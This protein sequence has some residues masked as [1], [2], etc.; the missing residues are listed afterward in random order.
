MDIGLLSLLILGSMLILLLTGLPVALILIVIA[1]V[2]VMVIKG[3]AALT[4][5]ASATFTSIT[6]DVF[7]ALP[8]FIFMAAVLE[9]SG[10]GSA[11]YDL[12]HKWMAGLRGGLAMGTIGIATAM[13]AMSGSAST[14][15]L[16]MGMLAYPEME[17]RGY[18][19]RMAIG[20][21]PAGGVLGPLIPPSVLMII[22]ASVSATSIGKLFMAG[23]IPGLLMSL[24]F[25]AYIGIRC[26][27]RPDMGPPLPVAERVGWSEKIKSVR[28]AFL[29]FLLILL[30]LG[31]IYTGVCAPSEA[32][33]VG[34]VGAL[35]SAAIYG[36]LNLR[37]LQKATIRC[38]QITAML[39]FLLITAAY[40]GQMMGILG[41]QVYIKDLLTGAE[42][43]RWVILASMLG[44]VF[45]MGMFMDDVPITVIFLPIFFP[46]AKALGFDLLWFV[47]LFSLD[48][49][50]GLITPPFGMVLFY[51][52]GLNIQGVTMMDI[53]RSIFPYVLI[54]IGVMLLVIL[55]PPLALWLP[56]TMI[57]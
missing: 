43:S 21:I 57:G 19:K 23:F 56:S 17:R 54:A 33:G 8:Q 45:F 37:S 15:T 34:A 35:I 52:K 7:L 1:F 28:G 13:A 51:F 18:D 11:M 12:M 32:G 46:I 16:T 20:C 55:F 40:F 47:F 27:F 26:F 38:L 14:A 9:M 41:I 3:P 4:P 6:R 2:P 25:M 42:V 10:L 50:I 22:V 53:Y 39:M 44:L 24:G 29:P 48:E 30:V 49:V 5:M 36:N 31:L